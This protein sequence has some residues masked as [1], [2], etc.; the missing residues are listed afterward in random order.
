MPLGSFEQR[1]DVTY[2][3]KDN[4]SVLLTSY[5]WVMVHHDAVAQQ[6]QS[7]TFDLRCKG[8]VEG[9]RSSPL[10]GEEPLHTAMGTG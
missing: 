2:A 8:I 10:G 5:E 4:S 9:A 6:M 1:S 7:S 3:L